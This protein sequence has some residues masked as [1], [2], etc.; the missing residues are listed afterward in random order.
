[1]DVRNVEELYRSYFRY[2]Y[3]CKPLISTFARVERLDEGRID[4]GDAFNRLQPHIS[5]FDDHIL[6]LLKTTTELKVYRTFLNIRRIFPGMFNTVFSH[7][8]EPLGNTVNQK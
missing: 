6:R 3:I 1:M 5:L 4:S 7:L 2:D 8:L